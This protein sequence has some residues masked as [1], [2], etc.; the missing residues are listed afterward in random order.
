[1]KE[2]QF[3]AQ[4]LEWLALTTDIP[5]VRINTAP[6]SSEHTDENGI[7]NKSSVLRTIREAKTQIKQYNLKKIITL[8]GDCVA[9]LPSFSY[10]AETYKDGFGVL[11]L[12]THPDIPMPG[13][14]NHSHAYPV[15]S[16]M[17]HG[18]KE[19]VSEVPYKIPCSKIMIAGIHSLL[20]SERDSIENFGVQTCSPS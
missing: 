9:S 8:G 18:D 1:L 13:Q 6:T 19:F 7:S 3:G 2:Y 15:A 12:D 20:E 11:W 14:F 16:L 10:L 17:G 5:V 4:L